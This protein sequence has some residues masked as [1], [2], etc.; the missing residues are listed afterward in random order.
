MSIIQHHPASK[1]GDKKHWGELRAAGRALAV[2][3]SALKFN[4]LTLLVTETARQAAQQIRTRQF[5][6]AEQQL[7]IF[8]FPDW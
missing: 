3:E 8:S 2:A 4:G 1:P 7:P 5:F 6:T